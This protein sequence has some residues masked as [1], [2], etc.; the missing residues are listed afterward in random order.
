LSSLFYKKFC[1]IVLLSCC[2]STIGS[3]KKERK[4]KGGYKK[5][6]QLDELIVTLLS[7]YF[8]NL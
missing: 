1:Y 6:D 2:S 3:I 5:I 8:F 4:L 7:L